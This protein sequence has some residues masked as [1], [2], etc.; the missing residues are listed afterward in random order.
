M[1]SPWISGDV[2]APNGAVVGLSLV[3]NVGSESLAVVSLPDVVV[4][5]AGE[6]EVAVLGG[7]FEILRD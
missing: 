4:F 1:R 6:E 3:A 2:A 5:G 7:L